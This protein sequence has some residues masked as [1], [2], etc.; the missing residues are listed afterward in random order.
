MLTDSK[1]KKDKQ[2]LTAGAL[3]NDDLFAQGSFCGVAD[4]PRDIPSSHVEDSSFSFAVGNSTTPC[5]SS[6]KVSEYRLPR[7]DMVRV[8]STV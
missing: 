6:S 5:S 4:S 7:G 3:E 2:S 1:R 8:Q